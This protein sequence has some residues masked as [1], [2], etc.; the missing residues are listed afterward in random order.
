LLVPDA[1]LALVGEGPERAALEAR[2]VP[3]VR[4]VGNR[5]DVPDWL[6]AA[7]VV[8]APSRW[9]GMALA[10]LEAMARAR[11]VVATEVA[12]AGESLP[13]EGATIVPAGAGGPLAA[14]VAT[15]LADPGSADEAGRIARR[16]VEQ[17]HDAA[18]AA[19]ELV[20]VYSTLI[21]P[22]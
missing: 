4:L 8:V 19:G 17:H 6:A 9:E 10:P 22:G 2:R 18:R 15:R 21:R 3:G 16:H 5:T 13:A 11:A 12:G 1:Q 7:N 14:A 20:R